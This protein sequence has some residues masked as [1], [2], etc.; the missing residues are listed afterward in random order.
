MKTVQNERR[1]N[2]DIR[3]LQIRIAELEKDIAYLKGYIKAI[4]TTMFALLVGIALRGFLFKS[5]SKLLLNVRQTH[6]RYGFNTFLRESMY[7]G[8]NS[9]QHGSLF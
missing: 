1:E 2:R 9:T 7:S 5:S 8:H 3:A 6:F 4:V